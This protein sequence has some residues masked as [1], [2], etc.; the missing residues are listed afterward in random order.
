M[1][2]GGLNIEVF[3][4]VERKGKL[5]LR[6]DRQVFGSIY[7]RAFGFDPSSSQVPIIIYRKTGNE[8]RYHD[9]IFCTY[10]GGAQD[11]PLLRTH[12]GVKA[13]T[14]DAEDFKEGDRLVM[15]GHQTSPTGT[16]SSVYAHP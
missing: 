7:L 13:G 16:I 9:T 1:K 5:K 8:L 10:V 11:G 14:L 12:E 6:R 4:V 3:V 15:A 2:T